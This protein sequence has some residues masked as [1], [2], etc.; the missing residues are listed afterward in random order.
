MFLPSLEKYNPKLIDVAVKLHRDGQILPDTYVI[1]LDALTENTKKMVRVAKKNNIELLYM[2]KQMGRNPVIAH[3]IEEAGIPTAVVVDFREAETFMNNHL[4]I[5]NVGNLV[6][7]PRTIVKR[8][9]NYGT[10]YVT[11]YS[12]S[13]LKYIN[14]IAKEIGIR[15]K[16]ILKVIGKNDTLYPGQVGG[17][18][19]T[20]FNKNFKEI[21]SLSNIELVGITVFPALLFDSDKQSI[22]PTSNLKTVEDVE[23]IFKINNYPLKVLSLPSATCCNSIPLIKKLHGTEGEPGHGLTGTTPLHSVSKQPEIP[24]YCYVSE[25]SHSFNGHSYFYGGGYYRRGHLH[26]AIISDGSKQEHAKVLPF[27]KENIDYYLELNKQFDEGNTVICAFRTQI[28]VTRS[29][30]ALVKGIQ[31]DNPQLIG[32]YDSQGKKMP[33]R[34]L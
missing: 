13:N 8:I 12:L 24:A 4:H 32:L 7:M 5:G 14:E 11:V 9:L 31:T 15:Q 30:V 10:K 26:N 20:E 33:E 3:T 17:L 28:F 6:Q 27:D 16:V 18:T 19:L 1:D 25:I 34:M 22:E 29:P 21:T 23:K 2:T